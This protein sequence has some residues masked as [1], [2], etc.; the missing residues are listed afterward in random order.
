MNPEHYFSLR[1]TAWSDICIHYKMMATV[2]PANSHHL[3]INTTWRLQ[4][5][6]AGLERED[7]A[8]EH[9]STGGTLG[10]CCVSGTPPPDFFY[11]RK[12]ALSIET[13]VPWRRKLCDTALLTPVHVLPSHPLI[14]AYIYLFIYFWV[15]GGGE[16][17]PRHYS[18]TYNA[19]GQTSNLM[20]P[21]PMFC[22]HR[23]LLGC[24]IDG[25]S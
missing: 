2:S 24:P 22:P 5:C 20:P 16:K 8:R 4:A 21:S 10:L 13:L 11:L 7:P 14:G 18:G 9:S 25:F 3:H 17:E 19:K 12:L 1:C 15:E 6:G 23:Q